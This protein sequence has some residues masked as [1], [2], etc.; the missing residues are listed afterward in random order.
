MSDMNKILNFYA[1]F[2]KKELGII[3]Q[4]DTFYQLEA[5]LND[6][7]SQLNYESIEDFYQKTHKNLEGH[8]RQLLLDIATN[9]ETSFFRDPKVFKALEKDLIS[10][11]KNN[12][13]NIQKPIRIWSIACSTGQEPYSL[14]MMIKKCLDNHPFH[15][16]AT[17]ISNRALD[18]AKNGLYSQ[19]EIQRGLPMTHLIRFFNEASQDMKR[20]PRW[21]IK[22]DLKIHIQFR[23]LNLLDENFGTSMFDYILCRNVLI[24]QEKD[25]KKAI[26]EKIYR[27]LRDNGVLILG[28]AESMLGVSDQYEMKIVEGAIFYEKKNQ[29]SNHVRAA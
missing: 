23:L 2:I 10:K 20:D 9:N 24:Y 18:V 7:V 1:D 6:I 25:Q 4:E 15:I 11:F 3:Y 8:A 28:G 13:D 22:S 12:P 14:C 5:R 26:V 16:L 19:L 29:D 17:D 27:N 21:Q